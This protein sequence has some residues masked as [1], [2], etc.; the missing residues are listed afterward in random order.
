[1]PPVKADGEKNYLGLPFNMRQDLLRIM[2]L[3][4]QD[5][6]D[7]SPASGDYSVPESFQNC[8]GV[9]VDTTGIVKLTYV[10]DHDATERTIVCVLNSGTYVPI[11]NVKTVHQKYNGSD[12]ITG[13][14]YNSAGSLVIGVHLLR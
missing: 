2:M 9:M 13:T 7:A 10:T 4:F 3:G 8:R 1:M 14:I 6:H 11:R 12:N 5:H